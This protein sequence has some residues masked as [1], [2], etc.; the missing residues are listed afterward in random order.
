MENYQVKIKIKKK[1]NDK[2]KVTEI[3][4]DS[5]LDA[6]NVYFSGAEKLLYRF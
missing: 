6:C 2:G 3:T 1:K 4:A 5:E